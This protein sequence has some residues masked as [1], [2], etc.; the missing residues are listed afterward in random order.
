MSTSVPISDEEL[1]ML[2]CSS[3]NAPIECKSIIANL[4]LSST[5]VVLTS[6]P[7]LST[8]STSMVSSSSS[9][10]NGLLHEILPYITG[11]LVVLMIYVISVCFLR[12]AAK[13]SW[14]HAISLALG[15]VF[16]SQDGNT[17]CVPSDNLRCQCRRSHSDC[18]PRLSWHPS[19]RWRSTCRLGRPGNTGLN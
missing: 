17:C 14:V 19:S 15:L 5:D 18:V 16:K 13:L 1:I 12:Y 11:G 3:E 2:L 10:P 4:S 9:T 8:S 7:T 6:R